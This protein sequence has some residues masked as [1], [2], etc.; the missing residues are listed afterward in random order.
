MENSMVQETMLLPQE[1][2]KK[3]SGMK[4]E[5]LDGL[6]EGYIIILR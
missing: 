4:E 5:E 2:L 6:I 1:I 3:E